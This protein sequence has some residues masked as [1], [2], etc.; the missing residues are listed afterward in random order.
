MDNLYE[1]AQ[2]LKNDKAEAKK[3]V[4]EK[5]N[6]T[7]QQLLLLTQQMKEKIQHMVSETEEKVNFRIICEIL[8]CIWKWRREIKIY[9]VKYFKNPT[10]KKISGGGGS[11]KLRN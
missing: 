4:Y 2:K 1:K 11:I 10:P 6:Y 7:E 9:G 5:L 8:C 3:I